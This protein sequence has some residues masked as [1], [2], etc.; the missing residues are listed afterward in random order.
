MTP[1][2]PPVTARRLGRERLRRIARR[3]GCGVGP[4]LWVHDLAYGFSVL[5]EFPQPGEKS[6]GSEALTQRAV[7]AK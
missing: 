5:L 2:T 1:V 7:I 6:D 4:K 3:S